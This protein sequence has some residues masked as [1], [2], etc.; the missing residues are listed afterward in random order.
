MLPACFHLTWKSQGEYYS[1]L[2][3]LQEAGSVKPVEELH[4]MYQNVEKKDASLMC[5]HNDWPSKI[6][7][8]HNRQCC[9]RSRRRRILKPASGW[10]GC[11]CPLC[12]SS[13]IYLLHRC[14]ACCVCQGEGGI[15]KP[16]ARYYSCGYCCRFCCCSSSWV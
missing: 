15:L 10:F 7:L 13:T 9:V 6:H 8:L 2:L 5:V 14:L 16:I 11:G 3:K 12:T 1:N 4:C